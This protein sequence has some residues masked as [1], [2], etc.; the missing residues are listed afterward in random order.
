MTAPTEAGPGGGMN[1]VL[2]RELRIRLRGRR[3]WI[4]LTVY[5][6]LSP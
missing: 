5:L 6:L 3:A 2:A 4:L 1:P